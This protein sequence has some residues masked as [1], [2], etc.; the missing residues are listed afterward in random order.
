MLRGVDEDVVR[1]VIWPVMRELQPLTTDFHN[2]MFLESQRRRR[3]IRIV[4]TQQQPARFTMPDAHH[5][6]AQ[7]RGSADVVGVRMRVHQ[8][9][10]IAWPAVMPCDVCDSPQQVVPDGGWCV[11]EH[12]PLSSRK[13]HGLV[14]R[15]RDPEQVVVDAADE[16]ALRVDIGP[17]RRRGYWCVIR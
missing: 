16:I 14:E 15:V 11:D 9:A 12:N 1:G 13:E 6:T 2:V 4:V 5:V 10:D 8:V 3:P 7:Q 17:K